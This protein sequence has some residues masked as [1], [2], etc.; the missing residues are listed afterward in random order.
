MKILFLL[1]NSYKCGNMIKIAIS[2]KAR[3]GK[4]TVVSM[5]LKYLKFENSKEKVIGLAD[6]IKH[7]AKTMLPEASNECLFGPSEL[8]STI[9]S[10]KY[11]DIDGNPL[12]HRQVLLDIGKLGRMY[13]KNIWLNLVVQDAIK[14][15]DIHTYIC[16][17]CRFINECNYFKNNGFTMIRVLRDNC[18]KIDDPSETEQDNIPNSEFHYIINN[19][20]TLQELELNVEIISSE[21]RK[22]A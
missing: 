1:P 18:A 20:R 8:R 22:L 14:S 12:T 10:D 6:S 11:V 9:I 21:L 3:S 15:T 4:N 7:I 2:G 5:F 13:N 19:N 16:T 17:D